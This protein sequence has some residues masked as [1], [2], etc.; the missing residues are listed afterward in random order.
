MNVDPK[1]WMLYVAS[2]K[3][4]PEVLSDIWPGCR[5]EEGLP[6]WRKLF[7]IP[8]TTSGNTQGMDGS[9]DTGCHV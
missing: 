9:S 3:R 7:L 2:V 4:Y 6:M 5:R 1:R 8:F